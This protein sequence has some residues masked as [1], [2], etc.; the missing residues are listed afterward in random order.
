MAV[1]FP[2]QT[3]APYIVHLILHLSL[4]FEFNKYLP[5]LFDH[6]PSSFSEKYFMDGTRRQSMNYY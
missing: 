5:L 4:V 1:G 2:N 6:F 3:E